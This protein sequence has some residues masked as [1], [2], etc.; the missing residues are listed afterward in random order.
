MAP[1]VER[2]F[3]IDP[4]NGRELR[5]LHLAATTDLRVELLPTAPFVCLVAWHVERAMLDHVIATLLDAGA[6]CVS[7]FGLGCEQVDD[8]IDE[9]VVMRNI[10]RGRDDFVMTTWHDQDTQDDVLQFVLRSNGFDEPPLRPL[11]VLEI[12]DVFP[13]RARL[14]AVPL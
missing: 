13:D 1:L 6:S 11:L 3:G 2:T 5:Y 7:A 14:K 12:G 4:A 9:T 10:D 8:G